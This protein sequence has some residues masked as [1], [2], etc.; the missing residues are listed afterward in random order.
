MARL[1]IT[2]VAVVLASC[3]TSSQVSTTAATST[4]RVV[5]TTSTTTTTTLV[6]PPVSTLAPTIDCP[7]EGR[8][9]LVAFTAD[10][11]TEDV[12]VGDN[13]GTDA[14]IAI[15]PEIE[16]NAGC[17][18]FWSWGEPQYTYTDGRLILN[19][20]IKTDALCEPSTGGDSWMTV[21]T[22]F[23]DALWTNGAGVAVTFLN[24]DT[25]A[26]T[27]EPGRTFE[28]SRDE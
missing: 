24:D 3:T 9:S 4:T 28:F 7:I 15:G 23:T 10:G 17:N 13:A 5:D 6:E 22:L 8:W 1:S 2:V 14:W 25:M 12:V 20:I 19:D 26:W 27:L 21:E 16:G 11:P 18:G